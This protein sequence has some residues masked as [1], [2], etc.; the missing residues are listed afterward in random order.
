M[1]NFLFRMN[2]TH[3]LAVLHG[4]DG[5]FH[6]FAFRLDDWDG[7][8]RAAETLAQHERPLEVAPSQHGTTRGYTTY[9]RDPAGNRIEVFAG[10][11][12]TIIFA[13]RAVAAGQSPPPGPPGFDRRR[14]P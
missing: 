11:Y 12:V 4:P 13:Q 14:L 9:F 1:A 6:H 8:K 3:D 2:K 7:V 5:K 10:G